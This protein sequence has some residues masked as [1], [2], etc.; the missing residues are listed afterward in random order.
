MKQNKYKFGMRTIKSAIA[1]AICAGFRLWLGRDST[2]ILTTAVI[3]MYPTVETAVK[4]GIG[5]LLATCIGA[6]VGFLVLALYLTLG[7]GELWLQL[8]L[9]PIGVMVAMQVCVIIGQQSS[10]PIAAIVVIAIAV[11]YSDSITSAAAYSLSRLV[12]TAIGVGVATLVNLFIAPY[13]GDDGPEEEKL[14]GIVKDE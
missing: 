14:L 10:A 4:S 5:R 9:M 13:K 8:L 2:L 12:D 3:C 11:G 1:L 7:A 6:V